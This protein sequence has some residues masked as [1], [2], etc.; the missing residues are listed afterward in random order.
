MIENNSD[1]DINKQ[2]DEKI[3]VFLRI[4]PTINKIQ[5]LSK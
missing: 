1:K 3:K 5:H 2:N 4:R